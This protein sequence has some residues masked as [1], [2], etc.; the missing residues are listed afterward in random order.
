M[1]TFIQFL[2]KLITLFKTPNVVEKARRA[3]TYLLNY[4]HIGKYSKYT[5]WIASVLLAIITAILAMNGMLE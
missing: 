1:S 4:K 2:I 3:K 5:L